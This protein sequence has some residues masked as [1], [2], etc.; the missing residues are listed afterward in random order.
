M[1]PHRL[2]WTLYPLPI[3]L[4]CLQLQ[5]PALHATCTFYKSQINSIYRGIYYR[6][7]LYVQQSTHKLG[8]A[9]GSTWSFF[10]LITRTI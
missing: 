1:F 2:L 10:S 8:H 3:S 6:Y 5:K 9:W 7:S 4:S